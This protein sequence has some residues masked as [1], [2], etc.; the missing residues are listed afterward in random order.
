MWD[1]SHICD[2]HHSSQQCQILKPLSNARD[3]ICILISTEP[4]WGTPYNNF[5][6]QIT[7]GFFWH[8]NQKKIKVLRDFAIEKIFIINFLWKIFS[9][10]GYCSI[11]K[12]SSKRWWSRGLERTSSHENTKITTNCWK[13]IKKKRLETINKRYSISKDK[14]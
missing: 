4:W 1:Q 10:F 6:R 5:W 9:V 12:L 11:Y 7:L 13:M 3:Q 8:I 2:L 14:E